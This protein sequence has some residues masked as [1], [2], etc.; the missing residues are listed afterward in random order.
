MSDI[1]GFAVLAGWI[2]SDIDALFGES[3]FHVELCD[4][5]FVYPARARGSVLCDTVMDQSGASPKNRL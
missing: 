1:K 5:K 3:F 2:E 4:L